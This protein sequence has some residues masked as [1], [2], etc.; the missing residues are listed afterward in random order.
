MSIVL[1][2]P[3]AEEAET[4]ARLHIRCWH[5]AYAE[6]VPPEILARTDVAARIA[7]WRRSIGDASRIVVAAYDREEPVGFVIAGR[8]EDDVFE[9]ADGQIAALYI[10]ASHQ[11]RGLGSRLLAAAARQWLARGGRSLA[12]G[13]LAAN[14]GARSFYEGLGGRL[15]KTGTYSWDGHPIPDAIYVFEDLPDLARRA[16]DNIA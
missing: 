15:V 2:R 14:A 8:R 10:A 6:I 9:G 5:E 3:A 4:L 16:P 11:R 13:V 7:A 1:R 12:L